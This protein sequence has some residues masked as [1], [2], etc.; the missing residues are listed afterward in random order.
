MNAVV[1]GTAGTRPAQASPA[2]LA[3][4]ATTEIGALIAA[5]HRHILRLFR[6]LDDVA[7]VGEPALARSRLRQI[8]A[9]LADLLE[10][11][12]IAEEEI[13]YPVLFGRGERVTAMLDAATADHD[14]TR[15]VVGEVTLLDAGSVHWWRAVTAAHSACTSHFS[16][17]EELVAEVC[18]GLEPGVDNIL[19]RQWA[20]FVTTQRG[21]LPGRA[22]G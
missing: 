18:G 16:R 12:F 11:H 14:D 4:A 1:P 22:A 15:E 13:C 2:R 17:E 5:D 19:A 10:L 21:P 20:A 6:A 9:R 8:W 3:A 7:R